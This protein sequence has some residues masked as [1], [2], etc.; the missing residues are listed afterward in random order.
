MQLAQMAQQALQSGDGQLAL[1]VCEAFLQ[2]IQQMAGQQEAAPQGEPVFRK[3]G[4]I[5]KRV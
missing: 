4:V 2:L 5:V 3:G 1:Q